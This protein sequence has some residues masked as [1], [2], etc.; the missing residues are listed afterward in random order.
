MTRIREITK[1]LLFPEGPIALAD[2]SVLVVEIAG[3][4]L[5]RVLADGTK[6]VVAE[7]GGG[8]N[9][10]AIG[11]DG[12]CYV[13]NNGGWSAKGIEMLLGRVYDKPVPERI[14][15]CIQAVDLS[16]GKF[17]TLYTE[18][19]GHPLKAP[20]DLVFDKLGGFY[21]SD[22]GI[23]S[24]RTAERGR[25]CYAKPDGSSIRDVVVPIDAPNGVGLSPDEK[26][27]YV[28]QTET[29]RVMAYDILEPG[30]VRTSH[31]I[32]GGGRLLHASPHLVRMDS[33]AV[34]SAGN[35]CV[36]TLDLPAITVISP[37]GSR[38][39]RVAVPDPMVTN[40]CF[41]G[42]DLRT[43]YMTFSLGGTLAA[44]EWARPG[45]PLNFLNKRAS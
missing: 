45:L 23:R 27:L 28:A 41:G 24:K 22:I 10:A 15:S 16:T 37:D 26:T 1:G 17:E 38:V 29:A 20:N 44:M 19:A 2:G 33:L 9:G 13:C 8:P 30:V 5:T 39:E 3:G 36:A 21:F 14:Q 43:A 4:T 31:A 32:G 7:L 42:P 12:R 11:P 18:C 40:I 34:D 35:V 6:H 25:I